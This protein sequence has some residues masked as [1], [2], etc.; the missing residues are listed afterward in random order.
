MSDA[1]PISL[2]V[3]TGASGISRAYVLPFR[4][5]QQI[6][7]QAA[8]EFPAE[9]CG[10]IL[11]SSFT[12]S[13]EV[14]PARNVSTEAQRS[15]QIDDDTL[16]YAEKAI[17]KGWRVETIYHSHPNGNLGLSGDD[18]RDAL[19]DGQPRYPDAIYVIAGLFE[20]PGGPPWVSLSAYGWEE[21]TLA[22]LKLTIHTG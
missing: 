22:P 6:R 10:L 18:R 4:E 8:K 7:D 14:V 1:T 9:C 21:T 19:L 16:R 5:A 15:F 11:S 2:P 12:Q 20:R 3:L 13:R 17:R